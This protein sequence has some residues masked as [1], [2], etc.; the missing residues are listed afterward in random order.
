M[1]PLLLIGLAG[2]ALWLA[3][4]KKKTTTS[5]PGLPVPTPGL[6]DLPAENPSWVDHGIRF[7]WDRGT[8]E[9]TATHSV[10]ITGGVTDE[11]TEELAGVYPT[12]E[13]AHTASLG[14]IPFG[15]GSA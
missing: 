13:E 5:R 2:G 7:E 9:L 15:E 11:P 8:G 6:G 1:D 14:W 3:R 4:R 12:Q 10:S